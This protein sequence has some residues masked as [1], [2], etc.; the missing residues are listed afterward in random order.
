MSLST[1]TLGAS[2]TNYLKGD[3]NP[4]SVARRQLGATQQLAF[5]LNATINPTTVDPI[6]TTIHAKVLEQLGAEGFKA[7]GRAFR[8]MDLDGDKKLSPEEL[9][10]GFGDCGIDLSNSDIRRLFTLADR[11]NDGVIDLKEFLR[12]VR[13]PLP[14]ARVKVVDEA[15]AK[16]DPTGKGVATSEQLLAKYC[17]KL[18]PAVAK[19]QATE[20]EVMGAFTNTFTGS[21]GSDDG[22]VTKE[23]FLDYYTGISDSIDDHAL[24]DLVVRNSWRLD[25]PNNFNKTDADHYK[26]TVSQFQSSAYRG[27]TGAFPAPDADDNV[28]A[29]REPR[30]ASMISNNLVP[31]PIHKL[32]GCPASTGAG[33]YLGASVKAHKV[34]TKDMSEKVKDIEL[35]FDKSTTGKVPS[36][37]T[38]RGF[39][40]NS[41]TTGTMHGEFNDDVMGT[42]Y[43]GKAKERKAEAERHQLQSTPFASVDPNHWSRSSD[44]YADYRK[45]DRSDFTATNVL[46]KLARAEGNRTRT[47][48]MMEAGRNVD[49]DELK[50]LRNA[51]SANALPAGYSAPSGAM[52]TTMKDHFAGYDTAKAEASNDRW[53]S[54]PLQHRHQ[55]ATEEERAAYAAQKDRFAQRHEGIFKTEKADKHCPVFDEADISHTFDIKG[56]F[57]IRNGVRC[58]NDKVHKPLDVTSTL[59]RTQQGSLN[60]NTIVPGQFT[61]MSQ[62]PLHTPHHL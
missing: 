43:D 45:V 34:N 26:Y 16:V 6:I 21:M 32:G 62:K 40:D 60:R 18:H 22:L 27:C 35:D 5:G 28:T 41:T 59:T 11:N 3:T 57:S 15:W 56:A 36:M 19:Q 25:Q 2:R 23:E 52:L 31:Y 48:N 54:V 58:L 29:K 46:P 12:L 38:S 17:A 33:V 44:A 10:M 9:R 61:A 50:A 4:N 20:A 37:I 14:R 53:A 7:I 13:G 49:V 42:F 55:V 8:L 24:F 47:T 30:F 39:I 1:N 51:I